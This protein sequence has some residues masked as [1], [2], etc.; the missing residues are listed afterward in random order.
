M[1]ILFVCLGNICRSPTAEAVMR[2]RI[3]AAGLA[4]EIGVDSAG[5]ADWHTGRTADPRAIAAA[6]TR[7]MEVTSI[8]RQVAPS[9][10]GSF[11]LVVAMDSSNHAD[12]AALPGADSDRLRMMREFEPGGDSPDVPD[13]Y[14][15]EDDG[16]ERVLDLLERACDGLLEQIRSDRSETGKTGS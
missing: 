15:G 10:F 4:G 13:P 11:D 16:F 6:A 7:G 12:L 14:F 9:D 8:A 3:E 5:T 1:R 2:S